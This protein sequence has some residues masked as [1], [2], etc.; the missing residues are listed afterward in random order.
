M[1][2]SPTDA[3]FNLGYAIAKSTELK[4][5]IYVCMNGKVFA[6]EEVIK[7]LSEGRFRSIYTK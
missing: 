3:G 2:F 7:I 1:G 5:G 4:E 6:P